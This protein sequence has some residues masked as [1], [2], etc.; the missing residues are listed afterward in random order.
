VRYEAA[1]TPQL[2]ITNPAFSKRLSSLFCLREF[3]SQYLRLKYTLKN[4]QKKAATGI[5]NYGKENLLV[6]TSAKSS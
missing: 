1:K 6:G 3:S 2:H 5:Q 4:R